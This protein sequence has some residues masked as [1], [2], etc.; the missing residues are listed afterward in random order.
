MQKQTQRAHTTRV[1][2]HPR[3]T[4][5]AGEWAVQPPA[6]GHAVTSRVRRAGGSRCCGVA[7]DGA[8]VIAGVL[9]GDARVVARVG[10]RVVARV[11]AR[12]VAG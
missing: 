11:V 7:W 4:Y 10:A 5:R 9:R 12:A 6:E 1:A 3:V 2:S 8:E